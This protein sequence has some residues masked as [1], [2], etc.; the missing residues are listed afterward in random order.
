MVIRLHLVGA[1]TNGCN[2]VVIFSLLRR[3]KRE[4]DVPPV[5]LRGYSP[6]TCTS[7]RPDDSMMYISKAVNG[8]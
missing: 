8:P 7:P 6:F 1:G 5:V 4:R 2:L 3:N